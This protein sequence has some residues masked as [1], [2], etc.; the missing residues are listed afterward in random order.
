MSTSYV[1]H[2]APDN[3]SLVIRLAMEEMG[4][5]YRTALV[6]RRTNAQH[7]PSYLALNPNG[8][9]PVL[10]TPHGPMFETG[11]I[12]LWLADTHGA[13]APAPHDPDRVGFLKWL[14]FLS[15]TVHPD[16]RINFYTRLYA[17]TDQET[18]TAV[19]NQIQT[20][21][22]THLRHLE[23]LAASNPSY[24]G[25]SNPSVLDY[26][27]SCMM[28]WMALYPAAQDKSWFAL[29]A[30]PNLS[31]M[32]QSLQA[33]PAALAAAQAEGLGPTPFTQPRHPKPPEGSAI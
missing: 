3:A 23:D 1:L 25:A 19:L 11:A 16:L 17:G 15:N 10:E 13:M 27:L 8:L 2:Y 22:V 26:Y 7:N 9:I 21:L 6:D 33:R 20:R 31:C 5:P 24:L 29:D 12:L 28:R 4:V 30:T 18:Q 32:L 14:F